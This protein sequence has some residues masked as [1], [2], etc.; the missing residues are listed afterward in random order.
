MA[1]GGRV[2][3]LLREA[4]VGLDGTIGRTRWGAAAHAGF[5]VEK[6]RLGKLLCLFSV[7][8]GGPRRVELEIFALRSIGCPLF[9][10]S[11]TRSFLSA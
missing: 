11:A 9:T 4:W 5:F 6:N 2:V 3:G 1:G 10:P 8:F 7:R